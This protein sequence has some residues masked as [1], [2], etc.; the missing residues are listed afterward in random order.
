MGLDAR[1]YM[2]RDRPRW[3]GPG[4]WSIT[5]RIIVANVVIWFIYALAFNGGR[6][7]ALFH[8]MDEYLALHPADVFGRLRIWQP[9]TAMWLHD[10]TS[11]SH[12]FFNML[13]LYFF[14]RVVEGMLDRRSYLTLYLGG[15]ALAM[16]AMVPLS[17]LTPIR[18]VVGASGAVY[19][20]GVFAALRAPHMR[21]IL[22]IVPMSLAVMV[23]GFM[24]GRELLMLVLRQAPL[25]TTI[26]HL[27]GAAFGYGYERYLRRRGPVPSGGG[28]L[29][30]LKKKADRARAERKSQTAVGD[31]A[32]VDRLLEKIHA[33]GIS[34]LTEEEKRFL[35][36][37][38]RRFGR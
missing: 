32:R 20:I 37:S 10:P 4:S 26:G 12:I 8:L 14:G 24:V 30:G 35:E 25:G 19:A 3:G 27:V 5:T 17:A 7:T 9:F 38:S 29:A 11:I 18:T 22:F 2:R 13:F 28:V 6:P 23:Y 21:V 34:S 33:E 36:Q 31:R 15:G 16:L 1:D